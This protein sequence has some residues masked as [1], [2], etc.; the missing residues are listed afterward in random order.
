MQ[1]G[2]AS[3]MTQQA[4]VQDSHA[5]AHTSCSYRAP[6][7]TA[8][9]RCSKQASNKKERS[10]KFSLISVTYGRGHTPPQPTLIQP[11]TLPARKAHAAEL[12]LPCRPLLGCSCTE[13]AEAADAA[14]EAAAAAA[15]VASAT[16]AAIRISDAPRGAPTLLCSQHM[17][18]VTTPSSIKESKHACTL[19]TLA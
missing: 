13:Q 19:K 7:V 17:H 5:F 14:A 8:H 15:V 4:L 10:A 2:L 3:A 18:W 9:S 6:K 1:R 16:A 11:H 12:A